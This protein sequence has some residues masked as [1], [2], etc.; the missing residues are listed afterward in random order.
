MTADIVTVDVGATLDAA[1][2][3]LLDDG[4]GSVVVVDDSAPVGL[5]TETDALTAAHEAGE[6]FSA[7]DVR[8]LCTREVLTTTPD[9]SV[10]LTARRMGDEG[11]KKFPVLD[12]I[13]LVG[14]VT[15]SDIVERLPDLQSEVESI[16]ARREDCTGG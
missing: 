7:L 9:A 6:P 1:V 14:I 8:S 12:G 16:V 10:A 11:V 13:D 2:G 5:V 3:A 4:V 15:I